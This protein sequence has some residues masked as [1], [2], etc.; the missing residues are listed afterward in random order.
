MRIIALAL[1]LMA[2]AA[3]AHVDPVTQEDYSGWKQPNGASC[4]DNKDCKPTEARWNGKNWE[5]RFEDRWVVIPDERV[6]KHEAK[7]GNAHLCAMW[8]MGEWGVPQK[9][10]VT[11][12]CFTPP[13]ARG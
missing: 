7:D 4:C 9:N 6:L 10:T 5:A 11:I 13:A 8:D 3:H 1:V 2:S 12:F